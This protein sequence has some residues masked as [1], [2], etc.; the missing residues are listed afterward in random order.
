VPVESFE[1]IRV[2][3]AEPVKTWLARDPTG[4]FSLYRHPNAPQADAGWFEG[5]GFVQGD[6]GDDVVSMYIFPNHNLQPGQCIEV[7]Q[8]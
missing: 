3:V 8:L 1:P 2:K 6:L 4:Q 5:Q 7:P